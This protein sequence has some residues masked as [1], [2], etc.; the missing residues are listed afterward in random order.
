VRS[1]NPAAEFAAVT[2]VASKACVAACLPRLRA[3]QMTAMMAVVAT[4]TDTA[5]VMMA[6]VRTSS[7]RS[8]SISVSATC[9]VQVCAWSS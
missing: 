1:G 4:A 5:L 9:G 6:T 8:G 3:H 2:M 7:Q